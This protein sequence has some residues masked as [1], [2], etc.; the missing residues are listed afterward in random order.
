MLPRK[1]EDRIAAV[2]KQQQIAFGYWHRQAFNNQLAE[3]KFLDMVESDPACIEQLMRLTAADFD[4]LLKH[5]LNAGNTLM[6]LGHARDTKLPPLSALHSTKIQELLNQQHCD[7]YEALIEAQKAE[8]TSNVHN[9]DELPQW[10][11]DCSHTLLSTA[12]APITSYEDEANLRQIHQRLDCVFA[13]QARLNT[14]ISH[15]NAINNEMKG[16]AVPF[17]F[18]MVNTY[19]GAAGYCHATGVKDLDTWSSAQSLGTSPSL[20]AVDHLVTTAEQK[21][22]AVAQARLA[23]APSSIPLFRRGD[24]VRKTYQAIVDNYQ[25]I[26]AKPAATPVNQ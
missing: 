22:L 20:D 5:E 2:A 23:V 21:L 26:E 12:E 4:A 9:T 15:L 11:T 8:I 13:L 25:T 19:S 6:L 17:T 1:I 24:N 3:R 7:N 18:G 14:V 10:I 16:H